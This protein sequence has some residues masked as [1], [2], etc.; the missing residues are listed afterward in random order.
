MQEA[1]T[2]P[3]TTTLI[4]VRYASLTHPTMIGVR[5]EFN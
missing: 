5:C 1:S 2:Q 3:T 4:M